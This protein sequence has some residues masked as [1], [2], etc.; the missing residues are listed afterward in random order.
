[1][2]VV[3]FVDGKDGIHQNLLSFLLSQL[4]GLFQ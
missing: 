3:S 1:V 4:G 2:Q